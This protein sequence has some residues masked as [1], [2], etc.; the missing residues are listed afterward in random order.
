MLHQER[1]KKNSRSIQ[2]GRAC[3]GTHVVQAP[4]GCCSA[5]NKW[6]KEQAHPPQREEDMTSGCVQRVPHLGVLRKGAGMVLCAPAT[7]LLEV[8]RARLHKPGGID[9]LVPLG[10]LAPS[11]WI[12]RCVNAA[13]PILWAGTLSQPACCV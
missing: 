3:V 6:T 1:I 7:V 10:A 8:I 2:R 9:G 11:R 4:V 13:Q 5:S 12:G